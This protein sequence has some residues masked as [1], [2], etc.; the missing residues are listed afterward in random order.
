M[1]TLFWLVFWSG[2]VV[3]AF[4]AGVSLRVRLRERVGGGAPVVDDDAVEQILRT[5]VLTTDEDE[6]LD[7]RMSDTTRSVYGNSSIGG[8]TGRRARSA[9]AP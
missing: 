6:P 4:A 7:I 1:F 8:S 5:G 2:L 9:N 3:L